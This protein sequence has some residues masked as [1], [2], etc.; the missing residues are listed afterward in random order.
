T[1]CFYPGQG[2]NTTVRYP[3]DFRSQDPATTNVPP[4]SYAHAQCSPGPQTQLTAWAAAA[5]SPGYP[6]EP[7]GGVIHTGAVQGEALLRPHNGVVESIT[8]A[9]AKAVTILGGVI[10]IGSAEA[11]D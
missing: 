7:I 3:T 4:V 2:S 1:E 9:S 6:T 5:D 10:R 8:R 11:A